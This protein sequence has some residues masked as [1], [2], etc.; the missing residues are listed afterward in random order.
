MYSRNSFSEVC[1]IL[2]RDSEQALLSTPG[3]FVDG[4]WRM[5]YCFSSSRK[6]VRQYKAWPARFSNSGFPS[7][8]LKCNSSLNTKLMSAVAIDFFTLSLS[9]DALLF[10]RWPAD[11][12]LRYSLRIP[13]LFSSYQS[14]LRHFTGF[15]GALL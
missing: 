8:E 7:R 11:I 2:R 4:R 14:F 5:F 1:I 15:C 10:K 13:S 12:E 3:A 9:E 6:A